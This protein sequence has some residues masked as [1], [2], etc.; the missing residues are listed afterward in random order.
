VAEEHKEEPISVNQSLLNDTSKGGNSM[1]YQQR[2]AKDQAKREQVA[3]KKGLSKSER[4]VSREFE[5][6]LNQEVSQLFAALDLSKDG[7]LSVS[8]VLHAL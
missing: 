8:E 5:E 3:E 6:I 1:D 4:P 2:Q 7:R